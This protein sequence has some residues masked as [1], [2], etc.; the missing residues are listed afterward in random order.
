MTIQMQDKSLLAKLLATEDIIVQY[1]ANARTASFNITSRVLV[2]PVWANVSNDL[3]DMLVVHEV[4]HALDTPEKETLDAIADIAERNKASARVIKDYINIVEDARIDNRQKRR[5]PGSRRNYIVGYKEL[6]ERDFFGTQNKD[7]NAMG[8]ADRIN[9]YCKAGAMAQIKFDPVERALVDEIM[10][11][12]TFAQ[13]ADLAERVYILAKEQSDKQKEQDQNDET[14]DMI[15]WS[16]Q[17]AYDGDD[18]DYDQDY[19]DDGDDD[20]SDDFSSGDDSESDDG[21]AGNGDGDGDEAEDDVDGQIN[22]AGEY[23]GDLESVTENARRRN[24]DTIISNSDTEYVYLNMPTPNMDA[25]IVPYKKYLEA[26]AERF[27]GDFDP[28]ARS[29]IFQDFQKWKSSENDTISFLVKEFEMRKAAEAYAKTSTSKTGVI[30]TNK[31]YSY[32]YNDDIFLR[33][34]VI[35]N[36]KNHG[37]FMIMD[38]SGSMCQNLRQTVDQLIT[39]TMFC[40]RVQIPFEVYGF[41]DNRNFGN[42]YIPTFDCSG[43]NTLILGDLM[44]TNILSSRMN[45][46]ELNLAYVYLWQMARSHYW[47]SQNICMGGTPLNGSIIVA[48][49]LINDFRKNNRIQIVNTIFLTDGD[50]NPARVR[51]DVSYDKKKQYI[52]VD[53]ITKKTYNFGDRIGRYGGNVTN[54][55]LR[56]LKDRTDCNLIGFYLYDGAFKRMYAE[57]FGLSYTM[58]TEMQKSWTANKFVPVTSFGYDTYFVINTRGMKDTENTLNVSSEMTKG[59][60]ARAF[61]SFSKKKTVNRVLLRSF[62]EQ[63]AA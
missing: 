46:A 32:K 22:G 18:F 61:K 6:L 5:Y 51:K 42:N 8:L 2:M 31:L 27:S 55:L 33:N 26:S 39:L 36:G 40:K 29:I 62:I 57:M 17:T 60:I 19:G 41:H 45:A 47:N 3:Q 63:V 58:Q 21:N 4:G 37:F 50:S 25:I 28:E 15:S 44:L 23:R 10:K 13:V 43:N 9:I 35:P 30:D 7:V 16:S 12:D 38:F 54:N 56:I 14:E 24:M 1:D 52:Y 49:K 20:Y 59:A 34:T 11:A 48:E 53:K